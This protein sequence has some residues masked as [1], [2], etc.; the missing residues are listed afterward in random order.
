[1]KRY[2]KMLLLPLMLI[3]IGCNPLR[4]DVDPITY[5]DSYIEHL[6][7]TDKA[8]YQPGEAVRLSVN[9]I[10]EGEVR[11]R[12]C[13]LD[14]TLRDEVLSGNKWIW[15]PPSEDMQG[16]M[17]YLYGR[18]NGSDTVYA[19]IGVDVCSDPARFPRN[20]FLSEYGKMTATQIERVMNNLNRYHINYVQ[21]QDWHWKHHHPLGGSKTQPME[22]WTD[23]ISRNCYKSTVE[24]YIRSA[25]EKGMRCLFYNLAY[26]ALVDYQSDGVSTEWL[27][28]TDRNHEKIDQHP[29]S[30]PFKSSI[31]L[32]NLYSEEWRDY[33]KERN[34]EVY[35][36]FDFDGWQIDQLGARGAIY[37]YRGQ[38]VDLASSFGS[39][40]TDM[41]SAHS[42][43]EVVMNAVGQYGQQNQI[44]IAPVSFC[45]SE[46]WSHS[47]ANGMTILS[48]IIK[49]N[50]AWSGGKQTVLAA[51]LNYNLGREGRGYFNTPG[52]I[53]G[54]AVATAWGGTILQMGE[55]MLCN[56]YFPNNNLS[57]RGELKRAMVSYYDFA[58]AYENVLRPDVEKG[59]ENTDWTNVNV[60]SIDGS[61]RFNPWGPK[62]GQVAVMCRC[63][64]D[65]DVIHLL[66]YR[67][68]RH[69]DWCDTDGN[70]AAE[71]MISDIP[72]RM[73]V[74]QE[75]KRVWV[76]SPDRWHGVSREVEYTY[77]SS[78]QSIS[79]RIP[80][81]Q[82][83]TMIVVEYNE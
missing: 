21:F 24:A 39:F 12:Y 47:D 29:L 37:D 32:V 72:V 41:H 6:M 4:I 58:V 63:L 5:G 59:K 53:M 80:A 67:Q 7:S 27:L 11:V 70:Q 54:T 26:G 64:K 36:V 78:T 45:Y 8:C 50:Y 13:H 49:N 44:A 68:S 61:V 76:A 28:F 34:E 77:E 66:S 19:S 60:T 83:Y 73:T 31:Y 52:V 9:S 40:I 23:I 1:M 56:E 33:L 30:S 25:H 38:S 18:M 42:D 69:L 46:V 71:H 35:S 48:D 16:Y 75:P 14:K 15:Q 17:V 57:M 20:G 65:K 2:M 82:Y 74:K 3:G 81:L 10:P 79:M 62:K 55:H 43:K 51:Y 22:V